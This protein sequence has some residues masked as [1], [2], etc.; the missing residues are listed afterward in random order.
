MLHVKISALKI[1]N[2]CQQDVKITSEVFLTFRCLIYLLY[3]T[4]FRAQDFWGQDKTADFKLDK[5]AD[6]ESATKPP[7]L[8]W[9]K[10]PIL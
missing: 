10:P 9:D 3:L 4:I 5:I 8:K 1:T 2:I 7:I 6:F